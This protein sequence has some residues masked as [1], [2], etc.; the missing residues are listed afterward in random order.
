[1]VFKRSHIIICFLY[2]CTWFFSPLIA[3]FLKI[4]VLE[5]S[6]K[7]SLLA[8]TYTNLFSFTLLIAAAIY[9]TRDEWERKISFQ[10]DAF[11]KN[12]L[13]AFFGCVIAVL[14]QVIAKEIGSFL[15]NIEEVSQNTALILDM[16]KLV[17]VF[18]VSTILCA[19]IIE[20][21]IFRKIL[22]GTLL[23]K[24]NYFISALLSSFAF[25]LIHF[26]F[27]HLL[28]YMV[29]GFVFSFLYYKTETIIVPITAHALMNALPIIAIFNQ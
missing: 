14:G 25:A 27:K 16:I 4:A 15:F 22:F 12:I 9:L 3:G 7:G 2:F 18:A 5:N 26:D 24:Y 10:W 23:Q 17:P 28:V 6:L 13:W 19:P 8:T 11:V 1:M 21:V 20:E 29:M